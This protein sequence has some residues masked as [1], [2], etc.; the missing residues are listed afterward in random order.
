MVHWTR[1]ILAHLLMKLCFA[2]CLFGNC[3]TAL[4]HEPC[5]VT[6]PVPCL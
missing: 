1:Q 5:S 4:Y 3:L 2:A 6:E